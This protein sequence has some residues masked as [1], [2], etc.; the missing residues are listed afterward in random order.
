MA[1]EPLPAGLVAEA[2][3]MLTALRRELAAERV[4]LLRDAR[5]P[6]TRCGTHETIIPV[7]SEAEF[8]AAWVRA[9]DEADEVW[10]LA[11]ETDGILAD[12]SRRVQ[13]AGKVLLGS[14]PEAVRLCGDKY[15]AFRRLQGQA[16]ACVQTWYH[17][18][19]DAGLQPPWVV[20][21][22]DG[23]GCEGVRLVTRKDDLGPELVQPYLQGENLSLSAVFAAGK[24]VCLSV[25]RQRIEIEAGF[26]HLRG[27]EVNVL[28]VSEW[29]DPVVRIAAAVPGLWG[30]AGI[31][32]IVT[33]DGPVVVE[34]NP[35]LTLSYAGLQEALGAAVAP[36]ILALARGQTDVDDIARWRRRLGRGRSVE[37]RA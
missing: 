4:L 25:N 31:D 37:V 19:V 13:A 8:A 12:L 17:E 28:P 7:A 20:K 23:V 16:I 6:L 9:L 21:P 5:L 14:R 18:E 27:C 15:A 30:Y 33:A 29:Q 22:A 35:R 34:I 24:G 36:K 11:P 10:L 1:A 26:F 32:V 3:C 2:E